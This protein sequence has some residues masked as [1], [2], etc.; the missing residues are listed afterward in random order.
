MTEGR[1]EWVTRDILARA[2]HATSPHARLQPWESCQQQDFDYRDA[3][4]ILTYIR[5]TE[6]RD[7]H[8]G[9]AS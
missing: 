8:P 7:A 2:L 6:D 4:D 3:D 1:A 5:I 9:I